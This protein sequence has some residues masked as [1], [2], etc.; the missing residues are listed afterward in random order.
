MLAFEQC[1]QDTS[2][3]AWICPGIEGS[4]GISLC[5]TGSGA[6]FAAEKGLSTGSDVSG[7]SGDDGT[8]EGE[9]WFTEPFCR[10]TASSGCA[11]D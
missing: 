5:G 3:A 11:A 7:T 2:G 1:A 4:G 10:L 9:L 8:K 6:K